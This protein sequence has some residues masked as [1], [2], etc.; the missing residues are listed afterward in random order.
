MIERELITL[1]YEVFW[2]YEEFCD[3][4]DSLNGE[5]TGK[6]IAGL[7]TDR[8][9]INGLIP[10]KDMHYL[11]LGAGAG[12]AEKTIAQKLGIDL[13]RVTFIDKHFNQ[14]D[15]AVKQVQQTIDEFLDIPTSEHFSLV[16]AI[17]M[18]YVWANQRQTNQL[19]TKLGAHLTP[20]ALLILHPYYYY[21]RDKLLWEKYGFTP[22]CNTGALSYFQFRSPTSAI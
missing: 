15:G 2:N 1:D 9:A 11:A 7:I 18:E 17:G 6:T 4:A 13:S 21:D 22:F 10:P 5:D 12:I 3:A 19:I 20:L 14:K 16:T 8:R